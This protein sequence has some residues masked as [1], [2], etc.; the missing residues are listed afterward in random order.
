MISLWRQGEKV[1]LARE[2]GISVSTL[3]RIRG[4][5]PTT[6]TTRSKTLGV[7]ESRLKRSITLDIIKA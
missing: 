3:V 5:K 6:R 4:G 1:E 7:I 2:T